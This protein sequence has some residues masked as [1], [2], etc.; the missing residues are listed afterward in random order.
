MNRMVAKA[1]SAMLSILHLVFFGAVVVIAVQYFGKT[2]NSVKDFFNQEGMTGQIV[3]AI[4]ALSCIAYI[5]LMG[6]I[7]T[8]VAIN[9]NL[10]AIRNHRS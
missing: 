1:F 7:S 3:V 6:V 8:F 5:L 9:D 4:L 10:E 2:P